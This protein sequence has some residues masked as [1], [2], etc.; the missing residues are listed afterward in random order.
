MPAT[1]QWYTGI[2]RKNQRI[3]LFFSFHKYSYVEN[4]IKLFVIQINKIIIGG[5]LNVLNDKLWYVSWKVSSLCV[6]V[7]QSWWKSQNNGSIEMVSYTDYLLRKHDKNYGNYK[8]AQSHIALENRMCCNIVLRGDYL[9]IQ[10]NCGLSS[11]IL[12]ALWRTPDAQY[13]PTAEHYQNALIS[14]HKL[15]RI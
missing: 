15:L 10:G 4:S 6:R 11:F 14:R 7:V 5:S 9:W 1:V 12:R 3:K 2:V 8:I 13:V